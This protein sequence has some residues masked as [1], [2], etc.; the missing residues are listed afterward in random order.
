MLDRPDRPSLATDTWT[1]GRIETLRTMLADGHSYGEIAA[2]LGSPFTR[3]S[4]IGKAKRLRLTQSRRSPSLPPKRNGNRA[5]RPKRTPEQIAEDSRVR[6]TLMHKQNGNRGVAKANA[7]IHRVLTRPPIPEFI[8]DEGVDAT[9]LL[10]LV[11]LNE[12]TCKWPVTGTGA[13]TRF[14]GRHS[15]EGKPYCAVHCREAYQTETR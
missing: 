8:P 10:G 5:V 15:E 9:H 3:N 7:I 4:C 6:S 1:E 11:Q 14:C 2:A 13:A 12:H